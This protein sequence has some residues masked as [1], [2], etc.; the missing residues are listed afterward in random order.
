[1]TQHTF[2]SVSDV[3]HLHI[4]NSTGD[5]STIFPVYIDNFAVEHQTHNYLN[6]KINF[7][8]YEV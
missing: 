4:G 1:M 6:N 3:F 7:H 2:V 5:V 8:S